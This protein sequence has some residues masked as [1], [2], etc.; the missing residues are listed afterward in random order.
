MC[1]LALIELFLG[2][3]E[4]SPAQAGIPRFSVAKPFEMEDLSRASGYKVSSFVP[5][6]RWFHDIL[7]RLPGPPNRR[8]LCHRTGGLEPGLWTGLLHFPDL[9]GLSGTTCGGAGRLVWP[10]PSEPCWSWVATAVPDKT[11]ASFSSSRSAMST[12]LQGPLG[13]R[14]SRR[15]GA[16]LVSAGSCIAAAALAHASGNAATGCVLMAAMRARRSMSSSSSRWAMSSSRWAL[17]PA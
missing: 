3:R 6:D 14:W 9:F 10:G 8:M 11:R 5:P 7:L 4:C 17:R 15:Q 1:S 2:Q 16:C 13:A 12:S